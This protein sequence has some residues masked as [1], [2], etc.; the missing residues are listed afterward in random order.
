MKTKLFMALL[1]FAVVFPVTLYVLEAPVL[2]HGPVMLGM[3]QVRMQSTY[4]GPPEVTV[5]E[6][7]NLPPPWGGTTMYYPHPTM[8]QWLYNFETNRYER[9]DGQLNVH[10]VQFFDDGTFEKG[11]VCTDGTTVVYVGGNSGNAGT[12]THA[13]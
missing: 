8:N 11:K 3:G 5:T 6:W 2:A 7:G 12:Y 10:Y 9:L 1:I 13:P 4:P